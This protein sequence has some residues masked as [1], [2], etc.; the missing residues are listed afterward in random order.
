[1]PDPTMT[2]LEILVVDDEAMLR[3]RLVATLEQGR[4]SVTGAGCL[5]EAR[6]CLESLSFDFVLLDVNLPDGNGLDLLRKKE[7]SPNTVV[8][9]MTADGGIET[10]VEAMRLGASDYLVKPFDP[11][12]LNL[13]YTRARKMRTTSRREE[14]QREQ[15]TEDQLFFGDPSSPVNQALQRIL[16]TDHRLQDKLPPVLIEGETGT[17]K[18][19][20]ARFLHASGPRARMPFLEINGSAL[21]DNLAESELFGHERGA[22]TDARSARIGLFE[23]ADGGTLFL[24]EIASLSPAIQAKLLKV[25]EDGRVRRLGGNREVQVDVRLIAAS[26]RPLREAV[27]AG[28]FREDLF[29]RLDLICLRLPPLR[30]R[31]DEIPQLARFLLKGLGRKYRRPGI[32]ITPEGEER[33]RHYPWPGNIRELA[34]QIERQI[35]LQPSDSLDFSELPGTASTPGT[36]GTSDSELQGTSDWLNPGWRFPETGFDL[37]A[38]EHRLIRRAI[39]QAGGNV[40]R[41]ARILGV[42]RDTLRYR[43]NQ[44]NP[45]N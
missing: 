17:G 14:F 19:T 15:L 31:R 3:K 13:V 28:E 38:A 20:L 10:A 26:N 11:A 24:D 5:A 12:E 6:N 43:L 45:G 18:T 1:M 35:I 7:I 42:S 25:I 2:G 33:I 23:A 44:K 8:V 9:V 32:S 34:H 21:P 36:T 37:E 4:A 27:A 40:S 16:E 41:A 29:H 30:E 22:F 39:D